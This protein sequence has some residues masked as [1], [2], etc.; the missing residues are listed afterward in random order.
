MNQRT[1][2]IIAAGV[3]AFTLA[4]GGTIAVTTTTL[5]RT[6]AAQ[7]AVAQPAASTSNASTASTAAE[8]DSTAVSSDE[9]AQI[10]LGLAPNAQM[11]AA[12]RL[13]NFE[14][15]A[16]YEVTLDAGK[17]YVDAGSG[18]VLYAA[19]AQ[20]QTLVRPDHGEEHEREHEHEEHEDEDGFRDDL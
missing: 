10:A 6:N 2:M 20:S 1:A 9:A 8:A 14:G 17:V 16:A 15:T 7:A 4:A 3:T 12:P 18:V 19:P 5:A 11:T 13:V